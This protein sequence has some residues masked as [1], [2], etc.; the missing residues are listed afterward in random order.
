MQYRGIVEVIYAVR[1]IGDEKWG[2]DVEDM[3]FGSP[4]PY[5]LYL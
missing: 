4:L 5:E 1:N 3:E 2:N